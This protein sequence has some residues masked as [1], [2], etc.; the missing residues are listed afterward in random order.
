VKYVDMPIQQP[1]TGARL[2]RR[3]NPER[4]QK[5]LIAR[6]RSEIPASSSG[7]R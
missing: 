7:P 2:M 6:L 3:G 4:R 1:A 5:D